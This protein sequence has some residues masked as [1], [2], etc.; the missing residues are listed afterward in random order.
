MWVASI[1]GILRVVPSGAT[2]SVIA[3][4]VDPDELGRLFAIYGAIE[5]MIP[6][7]MS[8]LG[9][10]IFNLTLHEDIDCG[11]VL[12]GATC[13][14]TFAAFIAIYSDTIWWSNVHLM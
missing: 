2:R 9:T 12:Y 11:L 7:F 8:P 4:V 3:K 5:A 1:F 10:A 13:L 14:T 6:L